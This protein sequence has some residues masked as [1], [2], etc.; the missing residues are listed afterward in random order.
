MAFVKNALVSVFDKDG[1]ENLVPYLEEN[2]FH[3]YSTGGTMR[4][5]EKLVKDKSIVHSISDYTEYPEICDGRVKTLHPKIYGGILSL[6]DNPEHIDD[7]YKIKAR[8]FDLVVV[9]LY[10]F[11]NVLESGES[12]DVLLENIDIG[13]HTLL[14]AASKNHKYI[15]VLSSPSQYNDYIN[16]KTDNLTLAKQAFATVMKYDIAISNWMNREE[17]IGVTY[18]KVRSLKYGLN[19]YMK[20]SHVYTKNGESPPF[21]VLNGEPGYI[22]LLDAYYAIHLV[23]EVEHQLGVNC[24]ASYKHNSPAGVATGSKTLIDSRNIDPKSSFG[25]VIGY[26]GTID[27]EKANYLKSL[28][29]DGIIASDF[30]DDALKILKNKKKG[31]Y[32]ILKQDHLIDKPQFRDVNGVTLVQP[33]NT[34]FLDKGK[35][36]HTV[37]NQIATDMILGYITL[38]YTQSN[39]VC[40][41]YQ[42][43]VIG[44]GAGQQ[45]RVD[46]IKIAGEKAMDWA[47]RILKVDM[48]KL[49]N[50][51]LVSDAFLPFTD[52]VD[53]AAAYNVQYILQPGGSIRDKEVQEACE[54]YDITMV[55]SGLRAFTH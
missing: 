55:M 28:I 2:D 4:A 10:P 52:N 5:I 43:K 48:S 38:K 3:I 25:D 33:T 1:L 9:N 24:C 21:Q 54:K 32:V 19:P 26:S 30:T 35:I 50:I 36:F 18:N 7:L 39:C 15:S 8:L 49:N 31:A 17:T 42:G 13:G 11:E 40:F 51:V 44:I 27:V 45:N 53:T 6:R 23:L 34:S 41:V 37:G 14:R 22:N 12:S 47:K 29:S 20:P 16:D 46:C